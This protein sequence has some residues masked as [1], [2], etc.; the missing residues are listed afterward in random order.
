MPGMI[1]GMGGMPGFPPQVGMPQVG[2]PPVGMPPV[3]MQGAH[4]SLPYGAI[5]SRSGSSSNMSAMSDSVRVQP[6]FNTVNQNWESP[7]IEDNSR[8]RPPSGGRSEEER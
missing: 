8:D 7:S 1:Q 5:M 6:V 3:G 2:M 4:L